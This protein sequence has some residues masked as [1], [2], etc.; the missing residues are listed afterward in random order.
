MI[1]FLIGTAKLCSISFKFELKPAQAIWCQV[2]KKSI[3]FSSVAPSLPRNCLRSYE[4]YKHSENSYAS[5]E[6]TGRSGLTGT[7][8]G[9]PFISTIH[10]QCLKQVLCNVTCPCPLLYRSAYWGDDSDICGKVI[11][12]TPQYVLP[13]C[14]K[15]WSW[16]QG[17]GVPF[18]TLHSGWWPS[19]PQNISSSFSLQKKETNLK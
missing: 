4:F 2:N 12:P 19:F 3:I 10:C 11:L 14:T 16:D 8:F 17:L 9:C 13:R 5:R 1:F 18:S 6:K 7:Y 15:P